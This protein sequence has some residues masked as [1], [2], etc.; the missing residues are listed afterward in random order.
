MQI[1]RGWR[2]LGLD[3]GAGC[4]GYSTGPSA[5][6][7]SHQIAGR[8]RSDFNGLRGGESHGGVRPCGGSMGKSQTVA[9]ASSSKE[10]SGFF[11]TSAAPARACEVRTMA[12]ATGA[13]QPGEIADEV[14]KP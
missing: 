4:G 7:P 2:M 10:R 5:P 8:H 3:S 6:L 1:Y 13:S 11:T 12:R 14:T 9:A